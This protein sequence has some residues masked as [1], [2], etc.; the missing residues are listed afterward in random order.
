[1]I[2]G[3]YSVELEPDKAETLKDYLRKAKIYFEPSEAGN[4]VHFECCMTEEECES[5][6]DYL[7]HI[8]K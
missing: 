5:V 2:K 8:L 7:A 6:N 4:L 3:W 1:M